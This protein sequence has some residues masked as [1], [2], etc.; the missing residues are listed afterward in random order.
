MD[1]SLL[2]KEFQARTNI[3]SEEFEQ[4]LALCEPRRFKKNEIIMQAGDI[5]KFTLF[6]VSGCLRQYYVSA[7]GVERIIYFAEERWWAGDLLS[8]R[9]GTPTELNLQALEATDT[10]TISKENWEYA[11]KNFPWYAELHIKGQQ[12]WNGKMQNQL[13]QSLA[14]S[15]ETKYLRLLKERPKLLQRVPQYHIATYLGITPETLS[16]IRKKISLK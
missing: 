12:R 14:D 7:E 13:G 10:L 2:L 5:P 4:Y 9:N 16:R 1:T 15:P 11:F 3:T 8:M 6:V